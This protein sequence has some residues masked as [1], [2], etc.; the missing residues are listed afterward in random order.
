MFVSV[1]TSASVLVLGAEHMVFYTSARKKPTDD[2]DLFVNYG[3]IV[4]LSAALCTSLQ[5]VSTV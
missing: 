2:C 1:L 3:S 4:M 5:M